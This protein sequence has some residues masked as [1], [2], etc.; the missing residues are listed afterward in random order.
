MLVSRANGNVT[1]ERRVSCL[2]RMHVK[3][4]E[5]IEL[6]IF[7]LACE[8]RDAPENEPGVVFGCRSVGVE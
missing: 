5:S 8:S 6:H 7:D 2:H 4:E 3:R 1:K